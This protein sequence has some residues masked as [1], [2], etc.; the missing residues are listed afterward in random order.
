MGVEKEKSSDDIQEQATTPTALAPTPKPATTDKDWWGV[1]PSSCGKGAWDG[2][3]LTQ[4]E[5]SPGPPNRAVVVPVPEEEGGHEGSVRGLLKIGFGYTITRI[6]VAVARARDYS[7]EVSLAGVVISRF[8][9]TR[10]NF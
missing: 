9:S 8:F 2:E 5:S 6:S 10:A 7:T 4:P 3:R 1:P